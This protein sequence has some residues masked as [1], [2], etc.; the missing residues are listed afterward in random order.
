MFFLKFILNDGSIKNSFE[1]VQKFKFTHDCIIVIETLRDDR[2]KSSLQL[3]NLLPENH[4]I[5][6]EFLL[7]DVHSVIGELSEVLNSLLELL[8]NL[9]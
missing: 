3:F 6:I 8:R 5:I 4:E 9:L 1:A 7:V 2:S